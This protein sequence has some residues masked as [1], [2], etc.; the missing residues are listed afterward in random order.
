MLGTIIFFLA[1]AAVA[2]LILYKTNEDFRVWVGA[3]LA[4]VSPLLVGLWERV[5]GT[6]TG[7]FS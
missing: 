4:A 2:G 3:G 6:V 1:L 5:S 7:W